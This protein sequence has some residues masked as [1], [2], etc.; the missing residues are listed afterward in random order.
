M[1][2][3][4]S[5]MNY[6]LSAM[7]YL[8]C[9]MPYAPCAMRFALYALLI[10]TPLARG[11]VHGWAVGIV[12]L[13]T[14]IALS[15]FLLDKS[16][17]WEWKWIRTPLDRPIGLLL[18]LCVVSSFFSAHPRSSLWASVLLIN[19][20]VIFYLT[21]HTVNTRSQ[22]R[23]L[24]YLIIGVAT[25][26]SIFGLFKRLGANP[27]PWWD[28][29]DLKYV[30]DFLSSTYGNNNHLAG[31]LEMAIPLILGLL[32][33]GLRPS[34]L[35][36]LVYLSLLLLTA[37]VLTLSRGGWIGSLLGLSFMASA[38]LTSRYF[39]RK[40]FLMALIGGSLA[41]SL[42]VLSSTPVVERVRT[43]M[44]RAQETSF[45]SRM[46]AWKGVAQMIGEHPLL[47]TGP[48]TFASVFTQYQPAGLSRRFTKAH[49]DYLHATS[50]LGL[51]LVVILAWMIMA[52]YKK[53]FN[54]LENPS[55]LVR[56]TTLGA[57]SGVT[58]ILFHSII[59]FNLHIPANALLFTVLVAIVVA[60][61]PQ[62]N[63]GRMQ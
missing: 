20:V 23:Q 37:L 39:K 15:A 61:L 26:L 3:N 41:L 42:I 11:S 59:D 45:H 44:Q 43:V 40:G 13:V 60:P 32:L 51:P 29:G 50:E 47:G 30:P 21:I 38:M 54:K 8:P 31:Y 5:T 19:Y 24:A 6:E 25:F 63:M 7:S 49:N 36:I 55:R 1:N 34:I 52:F 28:Y 17:R 56:G 9:A 16:L 35:F 4:L 62:G 22:F 58:A 18:I 2:Y 12:H 46:V 48:G 33:T 27:F 53:G 57:M 14:L 10:F